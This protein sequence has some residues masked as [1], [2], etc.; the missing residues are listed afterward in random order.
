[1]PK[2]DSNL[3]NKKLHRKHLAC[4]SLQHS[5]VPQKSVT[6]EFKLTH[7]RRH[8]SSLCKQY[9]SCQ[10]PSPKLFPLSTHLF[11]H[12]YN[13]PLLKYKHKPSPG[14]NIYNEVLHL[15]SSSSYSRFLIPPNLRYIR[16][17]TKLIYFPGTKNA[18]R[19]LLRMRIYI[20]RIRPH[21]HE[22]VSL[23]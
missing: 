15:T 16:P 11:C 22:F 14:N 21:G 3:P 18:R 7:S 5:L 4:Y 23:P 1:M 17:A 20:L 13:S 19:N 10:F 8:I 12:F 6:R 9:K 2:C